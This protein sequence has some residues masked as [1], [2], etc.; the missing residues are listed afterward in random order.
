MP[1]QPHAFLGRADAPIFQIASPLP[2]SSQL[3]PQISETGF[4]RAG[5]TLQSTDG[6][7]H[8]LRFLLQLPNLGQ[9]VLFLEGRDR[10][11]AATGRGAM[12]LRFE[13][14]ASALIRMV[15]VFTVFVR[16]LQLLLLVT[17]CPLISSEHSSIPC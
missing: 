17:A 14:T 3:L 11:A 9:D 5:E 8:T 6:L 4:R 15:L 10:D 16:H 13:L 12:L 2:Q 7:L 1:Q